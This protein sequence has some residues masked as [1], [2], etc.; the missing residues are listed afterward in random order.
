MRE[1]G[2]ATSAETSSTES[3]PSKGS[4][5]S[6]ADRMAERRQEVSNEGRAEGERPAEAERP[7]E[8]EQ[9]APVE[10]SYAQRLAET[11]Q[12]AEA[13]RSPGAEGSDSEHKAENA[14]AARPES[15]DV[16]TTERPGGQ[17][18]GEGT[19]L[20]GRPRNEVEPGRYLDPGDDVR[21]SLS[22]AHDRAGAENYADWID[23]VNPNYERFPDYS[24]AAIPW[25]ENC[26]DCSR[27]FAD[28]YQDIAVRPAWGDARKIDGDLRPGEYDEM[29]E[30]AGTRPDRRLVN[31]GQEGVSEFTQDAWRRT[32]AAIK[33]LPPGTVVIVGVDWESPDPSVP[34]DE[35]GG[36]WFNAVVTERGVQWVDAQSHETTD[37]PPPYSPIWRLEGIVRVPGGVWEGM[38]LV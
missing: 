10:S 29:W 5:R 17:Q 33:D 26:G 28:S 27:A 4:E 18:L 11:R 35:A 6:Y 20:A 34:R 7:V 14:P 9:R 15:P 13:E 21:E 38:N 12:A 37:W 31:P 8:A 16:S 1:T 24:T 32:E 2:S 19:N 3:N 22:N 30:W 25:R 36:H 23:R